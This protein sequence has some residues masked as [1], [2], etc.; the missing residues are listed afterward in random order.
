MS[1]LG[2]R[3]KLRYKPERMEYAQLMFDGKQ[4]AW[5]PDDVGLII[6]ESPLAGTQLVMKTNDMCKKGDIVRVKL[7]HMDP[8]LGEIVW[9]KEIDTDLFRI[10]INFLE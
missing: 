4:T 6:D 10:G 1:V 7:G 9:R 8:L 3:K 5:K 2:K